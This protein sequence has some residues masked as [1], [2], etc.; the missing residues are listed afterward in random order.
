MARIAIG[1]SA[2]SLV[3]AA[4]QG[5]DV[6]EDTPTIDRPGKYERGNEP[7]KATRSTLFGPGGL[8]LFNSSKPLEDGSGSG[9]IG[10]NSF[11]WRASL[12]TVAFM[13]LSSAD[14]FGGVIITDWYAPPKTPNERFK[15]TV[16][17]LSRQLRSDAVKV[18]VFKQRQDGGTEWIDS[19]VDEKTAADLENAILSRARELRVSSANGG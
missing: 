14:P 8:S 6:K 12:D 13:P 11:L 15:L 7:G 19:P 1:L 4:C 2:L 3:L 16:Y 18:A 9:G 10:V 5:V 17:I